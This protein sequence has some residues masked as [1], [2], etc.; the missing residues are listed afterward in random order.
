LETIW[1]RFGKEFSSYFNY[2]I[3][4]I[5]VEFMR[6]HLVIDAFKKA[7]KEI[8]SEVVS[9]LSMHI[10]DELFK[11]YKFQV[12]ERTFRNYY[13]DALSATAD[14]DIQINKKNELHLAK[15][16]GHDTYADYISKKGS[17]VGSRKEHSGKKLKVIGASTLLVLLSYIGY[18]TLSKECMVWTTNDHYEKV[19][20]D[21]K[22]IITSQKV[23][24]TVL[25]NFKRV[26]PNCD[27]P[28][29]KIDGSPNLWYGKNAKGTLEY[30]TLYGLHP[31][32]GKT[33]KNITEY[34]IKK[35]L[36]N[37]IY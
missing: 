20:C 8:Q 36:C 26:E 31:A 15:Y 32:T 13:N 21:D 29:F 16:L 30:F 24:L 25:D 11:N 33:L 12:H 14:I 17:V 34:M 7:E 27:Y 37:S 18:D 23:D 3:I 1:K 2:G 35:H 28:Y 22:G 6:K 4:H 10:S 19:K 9:Q 5:K